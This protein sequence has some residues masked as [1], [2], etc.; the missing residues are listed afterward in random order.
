MIRSSET[1]NQPW[2]RRLARETERTG[3]GA[4]ARRRLLLLAA[5]AAALPGG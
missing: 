1:L 3:S 4:L 2:E 5:G